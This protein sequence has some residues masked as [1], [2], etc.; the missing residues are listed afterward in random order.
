MWEEFYRY[1]LRG[2]IT[3]LKNYFRSAK[4]Y[5]PSLGDLQIC[6]TEAPLIR[7]EHNL[8]LNPTADP[9]ENI[10]QYSPNEVFKFSNPFR[11]TDLAKPYVMLCYHYSKE[12]VENNFTTSDLKKLQESLGKSLAGALPDIHSFL[13]L[14]QH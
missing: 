1:L 11:P 7:V 2:N 3:T 4:F 12:D 13:L 8:N 5:P 10:V 9:L 14:M 6:I